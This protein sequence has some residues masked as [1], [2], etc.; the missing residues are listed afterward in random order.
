MKKIFELKEKNKVLAL[1][2]KAAKLEIK[3]TQK[4]R[5]YAG[6]MQSKLLFQQMT[7]RKYHI[8]YCMLRGKLYDQIEKPKEQNKIKEHTWSEIEKIKEDY[9]EENVCSSS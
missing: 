1:A 9:Y 2:I 6:I 4:E 7:Y 8:A 5:K 3:K